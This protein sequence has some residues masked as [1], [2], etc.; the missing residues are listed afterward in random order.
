[1]D[2]LLSTPQA[3]RVALTALLLAVAAVAR[4]QAP[5]ESI[6]EFGYVDPSIA[7]VVSRARTAALR[8]LGVPKCR[9]LFSEFADLSGVPLDQVLTAAGETAESRLGRMA[10]LDGARVP[11]CGRRDV[12]AFTK[13]GSLS[14]QLCRN[15]RKLALRNAASAAN[16]LIHEMLHSLG[17]GEAPHTGVM[18][19]YE[20]TARVESRCGG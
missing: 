15:F 20:I 1:M 3:R 10:F 18:D 16:L 12:Y 17:A 13:P 8:K 7:T 6:E 2:A 5:V 4:A 11:P 9:Q 14:I 19:G